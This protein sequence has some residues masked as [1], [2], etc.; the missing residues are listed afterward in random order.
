MFDKK[1]ILPVF[2]AAMQDGYANNSNARKSTIAKFHG[3]KM[4]LFNSGDFKVQ[5]SYLVVP[6]SSRSSGQTVILY[7]DEPVWSM[8][9]QGGYNKDAIPFL[10]Q[11]LRETYGR[12]QFIG[13]RG[14]HIFAEDAM[15]YL[16]VLEYPNDWRH[17]R[18]HEEV[19]RNGQTLGWHEYQG[20]LLVE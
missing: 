11:A 14:P 10:K 20:L 19:R 15:A 3:L 5:D 6:G 12:S 7:K 17:F 13:G 9:Y 1:Q 8:S 16:N 2:F 4:I 18:G